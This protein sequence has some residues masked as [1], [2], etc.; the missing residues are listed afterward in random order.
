MTVRR[1]AWGLAAVSIVALTVAGCGNA[2][3]PGPNPSSTFVP[4]RRPPSV[5]AAVECSA[6]DVQLPQV[7]E[8]QDVALA[9]S[10]D[11][12]RTS[13]LLRNTGRLSVIVIPDEDGATRLL[14]APYADP[15]DAAS[16]A[17]L[18][19][20]AN[21]GTIDSVPGLPGGIPL[22][23]VF[24]GPPQWAV[25]G[26]TGQ[27][28]RVAGVRFLRDKASSAEYFAAKY[29]ADQLSTR[30]TPTALKT[31]RTLATCAKGAL[32][33]LQQDPGLQGL[34][35]YTR[36]IGTESACRSSYK[37]P[38][39]NDEEA[40]QKMESRTLHLLEKSPTLLENSKFF[41]ALARAR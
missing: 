33:L 37:T 20:V 38:L 9:A 40:A 24:I 17:A 16:E 5:Q 28:G 26:V 1:W 7:S 25:C 21:R 4:P 39:G 41:V 23:Q 31:G 8:A 2:S 15:T 11:A 14:T 18:I 35:L 29:L 6:S 13:L 3:D 12:T 30:V 27:L 22:S 10:T 32:Q 34:D 36:V 19:A